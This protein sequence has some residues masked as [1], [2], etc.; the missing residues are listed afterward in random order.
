MSDENKIDWSTNAVRQMKKI[1]KRYVGPIREK[2]KQLKDFPKVDLDIKKLMDGKNKY[3]LRVGD[4]RIIF[5][6]N[7]GKPT[8]ITIQQVSRRKTQTYRH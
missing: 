6:V 3:R 7:G 8:I 4:Y 5:E 1:D 2:V